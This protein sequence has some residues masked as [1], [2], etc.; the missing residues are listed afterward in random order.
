VVVILGFMHFSNMRLLVRY[1]ASKLF[2]VLTTTDYPSNR[3]GGVDAEAWCANPAIKPGH[4]DGT[5]PRVASIMS[6]VPDG[7]VLPIDAGVLFNKSASSLL[8]VVSA[9]SSGSYR[10]AAKE[11][12]APAHSNCGIFIDIPQLMWLC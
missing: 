2:K 4:A 1:R 10:F 3:L 7:V 6:T 9:G 8:S 12:G 11:L 5:Y